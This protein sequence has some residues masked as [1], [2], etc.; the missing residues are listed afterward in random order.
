MLRFNWLFVL[1]DV[2]LRYILLFSIHCMTLKNTSNSLINAFIACVFLYFQNFVHGAELLISNHICLICIQA[3]M[4]V[5]L[6]IF[7]KVVGEY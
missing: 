4:L 7:F 5:A 1:F 2:S 6:Y 3:L